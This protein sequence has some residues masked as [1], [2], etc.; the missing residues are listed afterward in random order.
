MEPKKP[1]HLQVVAGSKSSLPPDTSSREAGLS[2]LVRSQN[3]LIDELKQK[4][5]SLEHQIGVLIRGDIKLAER[6]IIRNQQKR[7][8]ELESANEL[9]KDLAT[10]AQTELESLQA[11]YAKLF[12]AFEERLSAESILEM[13]QQEIDEATRNFQRVNTQLVELQSAQS[14]RD[15]LYDELKGLHEQLTREDKLMLTQLA[16]TQYLIIMDMLSNLSLEWLQSDQPEKCR[17]GF[18][19]QTQIL[20]RWKKRSH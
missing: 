10:V 5:K 14:V 4:V 11:E 16:P 3:V 20:E 7:I 8:N 17:D 6:R 15:M 9:T 2:D 1:P 18:L 12:T 13:M 19:L